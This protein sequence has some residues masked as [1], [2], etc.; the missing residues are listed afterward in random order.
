MRHGRGFGTFR[1]RLERLPAG[2]PDCHAAQ[3]RASR[4]TAIAL[5]LAVAC[6]SAGGSPVGRGDYFSEV[7][8]VSQNA[9]IQERGLER[10]LAGR[11]KRAATPAERLT[12]LEIYLDQR[13]RLYEDVADALAALDPFEGLDAAH[14]GYVETWQQ[15]LELVRKV[16]DA[17]FDSVTD[18][19][20][21]L[22]TSAFETARTAVETA[23]E[24]LQTVAAAAERPVDLACDDRPS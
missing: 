9:H 19:E 5:L 7:A 18:Y 10:E 13:T 8:R 12:T 17:G 16:R 21:A 6:S 20:D 11:L 4:A 14:D 24:D 22:A 2:R 3:V 15:L 23:C 1:V